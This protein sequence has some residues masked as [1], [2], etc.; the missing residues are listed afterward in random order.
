[1]LHR[2]KKGSR[3]TNQTPPGQDQLS[4]DIIIPAQGEFG[5]DIPARDGKLANLFL[6]CT[7]FLFAMEITVCVMC[8]FPPVIFTLFKEYRLGAKIYF[9][10]FI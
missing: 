8:F 2:K 5:S 7:N 3:V 6:R 4:F 10:L 9:V 1:M